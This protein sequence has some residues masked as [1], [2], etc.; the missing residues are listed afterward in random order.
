MPR[1]PARAWRCGSTAELGVVVGAAAALARAQAA[2]PGAPQALLH[3]SGMSSSAGAVQVV[4]R[5]VG[6]STAGKV[7]TLA[8]P[9]HLPRSGGR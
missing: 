3:S 6:R 9:G 1:L 2:Q 8:R 4:A 7:S 5:A